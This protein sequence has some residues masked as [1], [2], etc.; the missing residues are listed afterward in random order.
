MSDV[1][2]VAVLT[3]KPGSES[4]V[5]DA[6]EALVE[7]TKAEDGNRGYALYVSAVDPTV[8]ITMERWASHDDLNAHMGT[9]HIAAALQTATDHLAAAP[10]I[11]PLVPI[12]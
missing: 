11:H 3:A 1:N 5:R 12:S 6:L 2:V 8:F 10:A 9:A 7:P 4:I